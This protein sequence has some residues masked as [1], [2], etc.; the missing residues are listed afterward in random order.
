MS[1]ADG[2]KWSNGV[3]KSEISIIWCISGTHNVKSCT[4]F[5]ETAQTANLNVGILFVFTWGFLFVFTSLKAIKIGKLSPGALF[6]MIVHQSQ[7]LWHFS[8]HEPIIG[9]VLIPVQRFPTQSI[10]LTSS[11]W[12]FRPVQKHWIPSVA[13]DRPLVDHYYSH[14]KYPRCKMHL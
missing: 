2:W 13:Q 1:P 5:K 10:H 14:W 6:V 3:G 9:P 4:K 11:F 12:A 8:N 7:G